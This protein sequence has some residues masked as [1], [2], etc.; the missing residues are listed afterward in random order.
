M[1]PARITPAN[2]GGAWCPP[3]LSLP[4][5]AA[6]DVR[7]YYP[8]QCAGERKRLF[9]SIFFSVA[10]SP[11]FALRFPISVA[12]NVKASAKAKECQAAIAQLAA[13]RSHNP[14]VVSS[15]LT[16]RTFA[17]ARTCIHIPRQTTFC[18][19]ERARMRVPSFPMELSASSAK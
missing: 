11:A 8:C 15:I 18:W 19:S 4:V 1:V 17:R 6:H 13:R 12:G 9:L 5:W 14:K 7:P 2:M 3:V 10:T 16:G